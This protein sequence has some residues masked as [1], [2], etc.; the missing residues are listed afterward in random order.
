MSD[1]DS[2]E[3]LAARADIPHGLHR[4]AWVRACIVIIE[5]AREEGR[6]EEREVW[7]SDPWGGS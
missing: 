2:A 4:E 6:E 3:W 7:A 5:A 1:Q